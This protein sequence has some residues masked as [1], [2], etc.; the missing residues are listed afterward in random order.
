MEITPAPDAT[1]NSQMSSLG[2][3]AR[4]GKKLIWHTGKAA[5]VF[6]TSFLLLVVPLIVQLHREEQMAAAEQEQLGVLNLGSSSLMTNAVPV[7][8]VGLLR[9]SATLLP[10]AFDDLPIAH[11]RSRFM[12]SEVHRFTFVVNLEII[13]DLVSL[14]SEV[15]RLCTCGLIPLDRSGSQKLICLVESNW[16]LVWESSNLT[17]PGD[18]YNERRVHGDFIVTA[19][20]EDIRLTAYFAVLRGGRAVV[21]GWTPFLP[22]WIR[23]WWPNERWAKRRWTINRCGWR[24]YEKKRGTSF[25]VR[26]PL[27]E[28]RKSRKSSIC[29]IR[30][31]EPCSTV[32]VQL[33]TYCARKCSSHVPILYRIFSTVPSFDRCHIVWR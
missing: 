26:L 25:A 29:R 32:R 7:Q 14:T 20:T 24:I 8:W 27:V 12:R 16:G 1:C 21:V 18:E 6:G 10:F 9:Y 5:W 30:F 13:C 31:I 11:T 17:S 22:S 23:I 15:F 33:Y 28:V 2:D 19:E 4:V 3:S